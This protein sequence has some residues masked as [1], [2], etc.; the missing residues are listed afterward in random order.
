M[1]C[2]RCRAGE[3]SINQSGPCRLIHLQLRATWVPTLQTCVVLNSDEIKITLLITVITDTILFVTMLVGL[4]RLLTD[5]SSAFGLVGLLWKQVGSACLQFA[6][7]SS[8]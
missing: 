3:Y 2:I 5:S 6:V 7:P 1:I 8:H 4:F